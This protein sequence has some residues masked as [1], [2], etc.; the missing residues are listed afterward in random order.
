MSLHARIHIRRGEFVLNIDAELPDSGITTLFG[1]SGSGKTTLLRAFAGLDRYAGAFLSLSG[2]VWQDPQTYVPP[3]RRALGFVFQEPSLFA[4][5]TVRGNLEYGARRVPESERTLSTIRVVELLR[6]QKLLDRK[7]PS[8][9]GGERQRVA[10]ARALAASPRLLL[11]DEPLAALDASIK[12]EILPDILSLQRELDVP[13]IYVSHNLDEVARISDHL[14]VL[15]DG[16]L[17]AIGPLAE[18]MTRLDLSLARGDLAETLIEA[19]VAGHDDSYDL[20]ILDSPAGRFTVA[21]RGLPIGSP[22]RLRIAARDVSIT[23]ERQEGTSILN[24]FAAVV[25][26]IRSEDGSKVTVRLLVNGTPLL[27]RITRK[28]AA[29]LRLEPGRNVY[30]QVKTVALL[31]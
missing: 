27:A 16:S 2:E 22:M 24:I 1:P 7:P 14:A 17:A 15:E 26:E 12:N 31:S 11:M 6:I 30:A 4:H 23:T 20:T 28:S 8:L 10:I 9:S 5:L 25:D 19:T 13:I 18:L 29:A 3:H 21:R